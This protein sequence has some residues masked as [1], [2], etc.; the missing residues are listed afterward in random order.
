L[1]LVTSVMKISLK[2][3]DRKTV[4]NGDE[5]NWGKF[6]TLY[7]VQGLNDGLKVTTDLNELAEFVHN[8][9]IV[10][11]N[12]LWELLEN[13]YTVKG[14]YSKEKRLSHV[15]MCTPY[16]WLSREDQLKDIYTIKD[17]LNKKDWVKLGGNFYEKDF[18]KYNIGW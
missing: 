13:G 17:I 9:W 11:V 4:G 5:I 6:S 15:A 16:E 18:I 7:S 1:S 12:H 8:A 3:I 14:G 2:T 10:G